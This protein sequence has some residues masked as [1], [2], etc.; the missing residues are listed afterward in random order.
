MLVLLAMPAS[1]PGG[2]SGAAPSSPG[3]GPADLCKIIQVCL[4]VS[5]LKASS[6]IRAV[7]LGGRSGG[8]P[9]IFRVQVE[10]SI[11]PGL[12]QLQNKQSTRREPEVPV[13]VLVGPQH[14]DKKTDSLQDPRKIRCGL[15]LERATTLGP[16]SLIEPNQEPGIAR[17]SLH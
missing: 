10:Q 12:M 13:Q 1:L 6:L 4:W 17:L 14:P 15:G 11:P 2:P 7:G 9:D 8:G 5:E 3:D 16:K